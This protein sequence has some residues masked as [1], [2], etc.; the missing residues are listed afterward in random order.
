M[1]G[2]IQFNSFYTKAYS[3]SILRYI[4]SKANKTNFINGLHRIKLYHVQV[5]CENTTA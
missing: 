2:K 5:N 3:V 4:H 1:L